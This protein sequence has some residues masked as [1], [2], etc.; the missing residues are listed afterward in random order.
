MEHLVPKGPDKG[1]SPSPTWGLLGRWPPWSNFAPED[2]LL[3]LSCGSVIVK[4]MGPPTNIFWPVLCLYKQSPS[5]SE[6]C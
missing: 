2:N 3:R 6:H 4:Y 1:L 5:S